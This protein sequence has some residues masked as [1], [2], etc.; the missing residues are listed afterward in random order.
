MIAPFG[1]SDLMIDPGLVR[2][3]GM[4]ACFGVA[5]MA[6]LEARA[7]GAAIRSTP[8]KSPRRV[9]AGR[10]LGFVREQQGFCGATS[11]ACSVPF[12]VVPELSAQLNR[13]RS[14][15]GVG[16]GGDTEVQGE[17]DIER[18]KPGLA[19]TG[20]VTYDSCTTRRR[21]ILG[22]PGHAALSDGADQRQRRLDV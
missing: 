7:A 21:P 12:V 15:G 9:P 20:T 10:V 17:P 2:A 3:S 18:R 1:A 4:A 11:P 8:L 6:P 22:C 13:S 16:H 5:A 14:G 19:V